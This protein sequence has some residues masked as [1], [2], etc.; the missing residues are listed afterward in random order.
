MKRDEIEAFQ[1]RI[2]PYLERAGDKK[3]LEAVCRMAAA[4]SE[5]LERKADLLSDLE[6]SM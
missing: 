4:L 6:I 5:A 2:A 1:E 3:E